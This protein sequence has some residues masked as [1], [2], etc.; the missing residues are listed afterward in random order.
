MTKLKLLDSMPNTS[1]SARSPDILPDGHVVC[2][3][4]G[5]PDGSGRVFNLHLDQW[6]VS[7]L[8]LRSGLQ[9]FGYLNRC[10][11]FGMPLSKSNAHLIF[12]ANHWVK[13]NVHY[14]RFRWNDGFCEAGE[15]AGEYL[16]RV[17]LQIVSG[18]IVVGTGQ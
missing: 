3:L 5:I 6:R 9:C 7:L 8:V 10:P 14:A 16:T 17:P 18:E 1:A 11:H 2:R 12:E 4:E 15:C 13:C